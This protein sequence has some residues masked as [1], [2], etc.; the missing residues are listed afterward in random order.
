VGGH[1]SSR[2]TNYGHLFVQPLT[3]PTV[4]RQLDY[5]LRMDWGV[6]GAGAVSEDVD[7]AVVIDV[8]SFTTTL[9]VA[10]DRDVTVFPYPWRDDTAQTFA[11][12]RSAVL[13]VGRSQAGPGQVSLSPQTVRAAP[14]LTR[15]VLPSPN[16]SS[17]SARLNTDRATVIGVSLR[18]RRAAADWLCQQRAA[19]PGI[20]IAVIAAGERWPDDTL[21]PAVEDL[22]G[23]GALITELV[24]RG[25]DG[26][27]PEAHAARAAYAVVADDLHH[28]LHTCASG[29]E[30]SSID[31]G[32]DVDTA[33]ELDRSRSL[34]ILRGDAFE[35][36]R[37]L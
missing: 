16:G 26:V 23:A 29:R 19:L 10:A 15:L 7:I 12:Q 32:G 8:L 6:V 34:P 24:D 5:T 28:A 3:P 18:N 14:G 21:R 27:S 9:S 13:A 4:H 35:P 33:A 2:R 36:H 17:I 11:V 25:W 20:R 22:W 31:F 1:G 37:V 30:L